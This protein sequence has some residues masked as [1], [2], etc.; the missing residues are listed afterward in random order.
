MQSVGERYERTS[1]AFLRVALSLT[2]ET[3]H[4]SVWRV[5][6]EIGLF[7]DLADLS[8]AGVLPLRRS[9]DIGNAIAKH[10]QSNTSKDIVS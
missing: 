5:T 9:G 10:P 8:S 7:A 4:A 6:L 2:T 3:A 1:S